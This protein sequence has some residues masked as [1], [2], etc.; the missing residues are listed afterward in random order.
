MSKD[1]VA[2]VRMEFAKSIVKLKPFLENDPILGNEL[3]SLLSS[4]QSDLDSEVVEAVEQC[5]Y[6]LLQ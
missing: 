3:M 5:D 4:M 2:T 1:K 6:E